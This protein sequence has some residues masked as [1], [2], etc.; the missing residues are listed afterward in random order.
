MKT[1]IEA[2]KQ[3][4]YELTVLNHG[5]AVCAA[6]EA[7]IA[8]EEAQSVE[9]VAEALVTFNGMTPMYAPLSQLPVGKTLLFTRPAPA[10]TPLDSERE[11]LVTKLR[12]ASNVIDGEV[13]DHITETVMEAADMLEADAQQAGVYKEHAKLRL[14]QVGMMLRLEIEDLKA[15]QVEVPQDQTRD[16]L[17]DYDHENGMYMNICHNCKCEFTGHKRR[18]TCKVC[19]D[20]WYARTYPSAPQHQKSGW[21]LVPIEPT[22]EMRV[23]LR[24]FGSLTSEQTKQVYRAMLAAAPSSDGTIINEGNTAPRVPMTDEQIYK[25]YTAATGQKLLKMGPD[26]YRVRE[27]V[28]IAEA[29]HGIVEV[30]K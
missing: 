2:M 11:A 23:S 14:D 6:L 8:R 24:L 9:P 30:N 10:K 12:E 18:V 3:A 16:W 29:H 26:R 1:T 19:S 27:V 22:A 17:A 13:A 5:A 25:A 28:R 4:L 20:E 21:K 7:A 15:Q